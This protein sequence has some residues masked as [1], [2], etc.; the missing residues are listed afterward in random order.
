MK[1]L[2]DIGLT[3]NVADTIRTFE[4]AYYDRRPWLGEAREKLVLGD[5][6]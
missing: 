1:G 2:D 3:L 5:E 6:A 4:V